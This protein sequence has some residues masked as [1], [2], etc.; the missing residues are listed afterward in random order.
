MTEPLLQVQVVELQPKEKKQPRA[1]DLQKLNRW[2]E[3]MGQEPIKDPETQRV[4]GQDFG[5]LAFGHDSEDDSS[6]GFCLA[7]YSYLADDLHRMF[8]WYRQDGPPYD[9]FFGMLPRYYEHVLKT[10]GCPLSSCCPAYQRGMERKRAREKAEAQK[11][12]PELGGMGSTKRK[13]KR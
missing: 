2:R 4:I 7:L 5:L 3:V 12:Q 11:L 9:P 13:R 6:P 1:K 10:R 8:G